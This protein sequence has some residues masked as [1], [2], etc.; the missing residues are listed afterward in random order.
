MKQKILVL[1]NANMEILME[2]E[3]FP[4]AGEELTDDGKVTVNV[5]LRS[6]TI[7]IK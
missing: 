7:E 2:T 6:A 3:S 5:P 1:G 4:C